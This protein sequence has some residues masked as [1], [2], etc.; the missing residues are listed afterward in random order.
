MHSFPNPGSIHFLDHHRSVNEMSAVHL[1][2]LNLPSPPGKNILRDVAG[3]F[4]RLHSPSKRVEFGQDQNAAFNPP[5]MEA[6]ACGLAEHLGAIASVIDGQGE[7]LNLRNLIARI[8]RLEPD[9]VLCRPNLP[10]YTSDLTV[11]SSIKAKLPEAC[12]IAWG[13]TCTSMPDRILSDSS[14]DMVSAADLKLTIEEIL[15]KDR[16]IRLLTREKDDGRHLPGIRPEPLDLDSMPMPA[17]HLLDFDLYRSNGRT[18][19]PVYASLGCSFSCYYCPYPIGFG[20]PWKPRDPER[21]VDEARCLIEDHGVRRIGFRDQTWNMD[22]KRSMKICRMLEGVKDGADWYA[23]LRADK[24]S[25]ELARSMKSCG[26]FRVEMG[27]ETGDSELFASVGKNESSLDSVKRGFSNAKEAGLLSM[28][29][30]MVGLP[31]D[32]WKQ[33]LRTMKVLHHISPDNLQVSIATPYPGTRFHA[34]AIKNDWFIDECIEH[35]DGKTPVLSYPEFPKED[36]IRARNALLD[37]RRGDLLIKD[38]QRAIKDRQYLEAITSIR[39]LA[40]R[41]MSSFRRMSDML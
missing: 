12:L 1:V 8:E 19:F 24:L 32:G 15:G 6:H 23:A 21:V 4:G 17:Y 7:N 29:H 10:S 37:W 40:S 30:V 22:P 11:S 18:F 25:R 27:L 28:A 3:G 35:L 31:G 5:A 39:G 26:C 16:D 13:T 36:I 14:F 20:S 34:E 38:L 41:P 33:T 2:M 9:F